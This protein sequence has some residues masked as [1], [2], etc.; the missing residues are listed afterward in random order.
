MKT[1]H[2]RQCLSHSLYG[3]GIV[4][5]SNEERTMIDFY[6]HGRKVFVTRLLEANLVAEAPPRPPKSR[7]AGSRATAKNGGA[8]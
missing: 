2:E 6:D 8:S 5:A 3:I 4:T 1:L 7:A